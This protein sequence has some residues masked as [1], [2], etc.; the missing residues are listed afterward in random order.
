MH[1]S[2]KDHEKK[3]I[4]SKNHKQIRMHQ[5]TMGKIRFSSN[6]REKKTHILSTITNPI[7]QILSNIA[8][9]NLQIS[10]NIPPKNCTV[11]E[12]IVE[13]PV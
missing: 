9:R 7:P 4:S 6:D 11:C 13:N 1:I 3:C 12:K 10:S 2:S 5:R 8:K